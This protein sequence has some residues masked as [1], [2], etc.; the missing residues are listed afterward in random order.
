MDAPE[1]EDTQLR[2]H[3]HWSLCC[4]VLCWARQASERACGLSERWWFLM[5]CVLTIACAAFHCN[6]GQG[7]EACEAIQKAIRWAALFHPDSH[8]R[9]HLNKNTKIFKFVIF[10]CRAH[11]RFA[12]LLESLEL[13][14]G[15]TAT[16]WCWDVY[17]LC[18]QGFSW[19]ESIIATVYIFF[20]CS[21]PCC[22][23]PF[24]GKIYCYP[25]LKHCVCCHLVCVWR[26]GGSVICFLRKSRLLL[27]IQEMLC[28]RDKVSDSLSVKHTHR[29]R[30]REAHT[31]T[32]FSA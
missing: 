8:V 4:A 16:D 5:M 2:S 28:A 1:H 32:H 21:A 27:A 23:E 29:E 15:A 11:F 6:P 13:V 31:H 17:H 9:R 3:S 19:Q 20:R 22:R 7:N 12:G 26:W 25:T 30:K 18:S 10:H 14:S 24:Q